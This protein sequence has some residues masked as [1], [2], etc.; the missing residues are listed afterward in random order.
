MTARLLTIRPAEPSDATGVAEVNHAAWLATYRD[1]LDPG[2]VESRSMADQLQVWR[3][4]LT[5]PDPSRQY[6]VA[7]DGPDLIGYGGA[8]RNAD[9]H[10]PFQAELFGVSVLPGRHGQGIGTRLLGTQAQWLRVMGW[11][12]MQLWLMEQNPFR[13]F[14]E[15]HGGTLLD[16]SRDLDFGGKRV[17][18]VSYGWTELDALIKL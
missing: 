9:R 16:G 10:S 6:F 11:H 3:D 18:V 4:L 5:H 8:G 17:T 12:S 1:A 2:Y 15:R 13:G 7:L 14:Y